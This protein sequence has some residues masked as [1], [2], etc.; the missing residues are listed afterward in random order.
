MSDVTIPNLPKGGRQQYTVP[1]PIP[2]IRHFGIQ[3]V[4]RGSAGNNVFVTLTTGEKE[5][6]TKVAELLGSSRAYVIRWLVMAYTVQV[7]KDAG[8]PHYQW[9]ELDGFD[10]SSLTDS[11]REAGRSSD[12]VLRPDEAGSRS[13]RAS[14]D[15]QDDDH[16]EG[17]S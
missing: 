8:I 9:P 6:L 2:Q 14:G 7:L 17:G 16:Q 3:A 4:Q 5:N 11:R 13:D 10:F 15:G 12:A 1:S